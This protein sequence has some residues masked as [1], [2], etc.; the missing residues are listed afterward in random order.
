MQIIHIATDC[1]HSCWF[2][3]FF[4]ITAYDM[5]L[6]C[7]FI[8]CSLICESSYTLYTGLLSWGKPGDKRDSLMSI[9]SPP[10]N[11]LFQAHD[12]L[13][14]ILM[15]NHFKLFCHVR[16][17]VTWWVIEW[18]LRWLIIQVIS[19]HI[20]N[21][22][23]KTFL[24]HISASQVRRDSCLW[25]LV[26]VDVIY[27]LK[28]AQKYSPFNMSYWDLIKEDCLYFQLANKL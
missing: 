13:I 3:R 8:G 6:V 21:T 14:M 17:K 7:I 24:T 16:V 12:N 11:L 15:E 23:V 4:S 10:I 20:D 2:S 28:W 9:M 5:F 25:T 22:L 1:T 27:N 18:T 26:R 19:P